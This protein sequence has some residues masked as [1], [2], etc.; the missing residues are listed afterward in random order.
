MQLSTTQTIE[1]LLASISQPERNPR[2]RMAA[3]VLPRATRPSKLARCPRACVCRMCSDNARWERIFQEKFA[4]P[5]YYSDP[6]T[7]NGSSL[8]DC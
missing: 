8:A 2:N 5:N 1:A 7:R 6:I 3:A 4:D